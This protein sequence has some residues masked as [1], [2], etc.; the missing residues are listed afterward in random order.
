MS[1]TVPDQTPF[2][3][4][5]REGELVVEL[6]TGDLVAVYAVTSVEPNTGNPVVVAEARAVNAD[7]STKC[8][9]CGD[10]TGTSFSH[11][12]N[13]TEVA[14]LGGIDKL[15]KL[16]VMAVLGEDTAPLWKDP[17][18]TAML[19]HASIRSNLMCAAHAGPVK[20]LASLL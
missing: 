1:Y 14:T 13:A 18:H 7:G 8:D 5:M 3:D 10:Q 19:D 4:M 11:C 2:A 16:V 15:Q 9:G 20:G 12:S 17:A 6:D